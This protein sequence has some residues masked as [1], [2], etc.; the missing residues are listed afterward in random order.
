MLL[1]LGKLCKTDFIELGIAFRHAQLESEETRSHTDIG[2]DNLSWRGGVGSDQADRLN[3]LLKKQGF[4]QVLEGHSR[5]QFGGS[6]LCIIEFDVCVARVYTI[7]Q[8]L[9]FTLT[10]Y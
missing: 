3:L 4:F 9:S 8:C 6:G 7:K 5:G 2:K 10:I 1:V